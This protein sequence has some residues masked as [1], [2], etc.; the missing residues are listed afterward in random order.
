MS[1]GPRTQLRVQK[2]QRG[3]SRGWGLLDPS[4][5]ISS[6]PAPTKDKQTVLSL[7]LA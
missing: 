6:R 7:V 4:L 2:S 1:S 5:A 3:V